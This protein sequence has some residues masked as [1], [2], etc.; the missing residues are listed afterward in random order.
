MAAVCATTTLRDWTVSAV[1][2]FITTCLGDLQ[3]DETAMLARVRT[4]MSP[5]L[6][7]IYNLWWSTFTK[8]LL[9]CKRMPYV[10]L[11]WHFFFTGCECNHHSTSCHFDHAVYVL[12]GEVSGGVCDDCQHNTVGRQ[13]EQCAPFFY[14]HPHRNLRDSNICQRTSFTTQPISAHYMKRLL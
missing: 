1:K 11:R 12:T 5:C 3:R 10:I 7:L 9:Y 13:C 8:T 14:Q 2:T 6:V 4:G